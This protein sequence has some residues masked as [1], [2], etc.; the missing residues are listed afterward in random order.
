VAALDLGAEDYVT[1]PFDGEELL[2]RLRVALRHR[3][4]SETAPK[5]YRKGKLEVDLDQRITRRNGAEAHLTR[6]EHDVLAVLAA[7]VGRVVT[8][9]RILTTVWGGGEDTRVEYLRIVIRNLRQKL[10]EPGAVGSVIANELGV[11]YR[12]LPDSEAQT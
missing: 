6:K 9:Q 2:A 5:I 11:G 10:E 12:L 7:N 3:G 8:H 4:I 1:K